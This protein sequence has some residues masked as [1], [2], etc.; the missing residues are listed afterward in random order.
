MASIDSL[1]STLVAGMIA[2]I[3]VLVDWFGRPSKILRYLTGPESYKMTSLLA[4]D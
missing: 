4:G 1:G 2:I 3:N